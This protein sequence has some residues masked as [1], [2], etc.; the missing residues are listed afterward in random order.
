MWRAGADSRSMAAILRTG[1]RKRR[2]TRQS[3]VR[4]RLRSRRNL[5]QV[6]IAQIGD[7][8][9]DAAF[10]CGKC[11]SRMISTCRRGRRTDG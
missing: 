8:C 9:F 11:H 6:R 3:C 2:Q 7:S 1:M 10:A 5:K 4:S